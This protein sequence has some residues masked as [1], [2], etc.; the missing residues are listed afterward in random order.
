MADAELRLYS[1][2][3]M[4]DPYPVYAEARRRGPT[5]HDER[6]DI[7]YLTRYTEC[8]AALQDHRTYSNDIRYWH[9]ADDFDSFTGGG[10]ARGAVML[11][12]DPPVHTELKAL[13]NHVFSPRRVAELEPWIRNVCER[14]TS[15][16]Q[17]GQPTEFIHAL[18]VPLPV[19]VIAHMLGVPEERWEDFKYWTEGVNATVSRMG[20][21]EKRTRLDSLEAFI[22]TTASER[23]AAPAD[24]LISA[25]I[26]AEVEGRR[27]NERELVSL[28]ALLL[29][30][31]NE[32]TTLLIGNLLNVLADRPELA[33]RIHLDRELIEPAVEETLRYDSPVQFANRFTTRKVRVGDATIPSGANVRV[34]LA[35]ANRDPDGFPEPDE[36]R[37]DRQLSRHVAFGYAIHYCLGAPLARLESRVALETLFEAF[38]SIEHAGEAERNT[39]APVFGGYDKLP[40]VFG[41]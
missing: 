35:S 19:L 1:H 23:R 8:Y 11:M 25:L 14:L 41:R 6:H 32:T 39:V 29:E 12:D 38:S 33:N 13:V 26:E 4:R 21:E 22:E 7:W 17:P 5:F 27:L 3:M 2:A 24:D 16:I 9:R 20:E 28:V 37:L 34:I 18:A 30:A 15:E 31:G 36:F 10:G 40:L